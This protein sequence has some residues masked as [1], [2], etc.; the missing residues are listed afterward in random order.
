M[1]DGKPANVAC[2]QLTDDYRC[3]IFGQ[4]GRPACCAGLQAS[5]EMCGSDRNHALSWLSQLELATL[6]EV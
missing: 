2:I 6:P 5:T 3:M 4:P 1:P